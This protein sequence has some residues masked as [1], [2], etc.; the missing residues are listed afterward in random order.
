MSTGVWKIE[1]LGS[2]C[3]MRDEMI[4]T[5]FRLRKADSLLAMLAYHER[6][7]FR[8]EE[9]ID[10]LWCDY[11]VEAGRNGLR[12]ALSALRQR[13]ESPANDEKIVIANRSHVRLNPTFFRTDVAAF[14]EAVKFTASVSEESERANLLAKA[15]TLYGGDL[16]PGF[17]E[18]WIGGERQRLSDTYYLALRRLIKLLVAAHNYEEAL[19]YARRTMMADPLREESHRMLMRLYIA[20]GQP[21]AA[22]RQYRQLEVLLKD[23]LGALP[24]ASTREIVQQCGSDPMQE[25]MTSSPPGVAAASVVASVSPHPAPRFPIIPPASQSNEARPEGHQSTPSP[26][27]SD[28][29]DNAG[30]VSTTRFPLPITRFFGRENCIEDLCAM[31]Q[32]A[33][34]RLIT[35]TGFGGCGKTRLAL[36]VAE[37]LLPR[38]NGAVWFV[39]LVDLSDPGLIVDLIGEILGLPRSAETARFDQVT[40]RLQ[41]QTSI[42]VI[43]NF[44]HLVPGALVIQKLLD[45]VPNLKCLMTSRQRLKLSSE[46]EFAV[47]PLP[48]P[49]AHCTPDESLNYACVQLFVDRART[50]RAGFH[51]TAS[52]VEAIVALCLRLEGLPLALELAAAWTATL[53]PAQILERLNPRFPLLVNRNKDAVSRHASLWAALQWSYQALAPE[54]Q[55]FFARL[56]VFRGGFTLE[57]AEAICQDKMAFERLAQ[58]QENS[59]LTVEES[60]DGMRFGMLETLREYA[61]EQL[62][63]EERML[64][65][66]RHADY[67]LNLAEQAEPHLRGQQARLWLNRLEC[68]QANLRAVL[69]QFITHPAIGLQMTGALWR[70]WYMRGYYAE[71]YDWL[72]KA[73][74]HCPP[75]Q[76]PNRIRALNGAGNI[77]Y[78]RCD[79]PSAQV[80]F[81][82]VLVLARECGDERRIAAALGGLGNIAK[83]QGDYVRA[84]ELLQQCL[85]VYGELADPRGIS[86]ALANLANVANDAGDAMEARRLHQESLDMFRQA[87]DISNIIIS[88]NNMARAML[89]CEDYVAVVP[90]LKE[91]LSLCRHLDD[92]IGLIQCLEACAYYA[93]R[94]GG[95]E[96]AVRLLGA[97]EALWE[98]L[99]ILHQHKRSGDDARHRDDLRTALGEEAFRQAWAQGRSVPHEQL[100][101]EVIG[102]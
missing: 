58:L 9:L 22:L 8:R 3:A 5:H 57:A 11:D 33:E 4:F 60:D 20:M 78:G 18:E 63:E 36:A 94:Q 7:L 46:R 19:D 67:Y 101:D 29:G 70:F 84:R 86:L 49:D 66:R 44:E 75:G 62:Q 15:I 47:L 85:I 64:V 34:T 61:Q 32:A 71:G 95:K 68:E 12:V 24:S 91:C 6:R 31:L 100:L 93:A 76:T 55:R 43:D 72:E 10:L 52:N 90:V 83:E 96:R 102:D 39:P 56:S 30:V 48:T 69:Q 40:S 53:S 35:L 14:E 59:L 87:G 77:A 27:M 17:D 13:L 23:Q 82:E 41:E 88:L 65:A 81:E 38:L 25:A 37:R 28:G 98:R 42:L 54:T 97:A 21:A 92:N 73:L 51:L 26:S 80:L 45:H 16:L 2:F 74:V 1:M 79:F 50:I 89:R 99:Q